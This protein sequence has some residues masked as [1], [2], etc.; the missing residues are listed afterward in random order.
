MARDHVSVDTG[1][2]RRGQLGK[3]GYID[4]ETKCDDKDEV[5]GMSC[6]GGKG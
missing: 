1:G 4:S 2:R 3:L 6:A 5:T